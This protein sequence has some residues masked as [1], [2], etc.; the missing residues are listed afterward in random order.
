MQVVEM[1]V[2]IRNP[3]EAHYWLDA[4]VVRVLNPSASI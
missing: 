2:A 3:P 4:G 1:W